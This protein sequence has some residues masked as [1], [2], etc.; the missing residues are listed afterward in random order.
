MFA[1]LKHTTSEAYYVH[2]APTFG[3]GQTAEEL[4]SYKYAEQV[5]YYFSGPWNGDGP[6][7]SSAKKGTK[8]GRLNGS[9]GLGPDPYI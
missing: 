7:S 4:P 9:D 8:V 6:G 5:A 3:P 2:I 1:I